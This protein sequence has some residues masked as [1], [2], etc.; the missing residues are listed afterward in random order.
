MEEEE[1]GLVE[2]GGGVRDWT[3][4]E[5]MKRLERGL[6]EKGGGGRERREVMERGGGEGWRRKRKRERECIRL[7]LLFSSGTLSSK[8]VCFKGPGSH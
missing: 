7:D 5:R 1:T 4:G 3:G 2:R 8:C 6:V